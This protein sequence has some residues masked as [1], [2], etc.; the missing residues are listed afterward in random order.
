MKNLILF[1]V[2]FYV[3]LF[4]FSVKS[5][6]FSFPTAGPDAK[7]VKYE[8]FT[9]EEQAAIRL[10]KISVLNNDF[11]LLSYLISDSIKDFSNLKT[12]I[13]RHNNFKRC[14]RKEKGSYLFFSKSKKTGN[15]SV[16]MPLEADGGVALRVI[17]RKEGKV[18]KLFKWTNPC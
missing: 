12:Q 9:K 11:Y 5:A 15:F 13:L 2:L 18:F 17:F 7:M 1:V 8:D 16:E 10:F 14:L 4:P 3:V 6:D